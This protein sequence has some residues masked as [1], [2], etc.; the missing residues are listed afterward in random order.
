MRQIEVFE[1]NYLYDVPI[2]Y[3]LQNR[4]VCALLGTDSTGANLT[5]PLDAELLSRHIMLLGGIG[6]GKTNAFNQIIGQLRRNMTPSDVM[7]IFDTKGDFYR[8]FYKPGDVVISNDN[9]ASG[10]AGVDYW[11]IFN[12]IVTT[13]QSPSQTT[14]CKK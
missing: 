6:T 4:P 10:P 8:T 7:I 3:P 13:Q 14:K 2:Q 5:V 9:T 1:G 11:N 12:E